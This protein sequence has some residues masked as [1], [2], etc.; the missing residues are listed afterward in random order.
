M[1]NINQKHK[2]YIKLYFIYCNMFILYLAIN[3]SQGIFF[4]FWGGG[5]GGGASTFHL[6][7]L[8]CT[9]TLIK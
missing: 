4:F 6:D 1:W 8:Q 5:G 2:V 9:V 3:L 7:G